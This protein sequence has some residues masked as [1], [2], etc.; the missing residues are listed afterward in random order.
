M[1]WQGYC[2]R[3][4]SRIS[5]IAGIH[6]WPLQLGNLSL[7]RSRRSATYLADRGSGKGYS[8]SV[9]GG[10]VFGTRNEDI[11]VLRGIAV[12]LVVLHHS[13]VIPIPAGYL[14][15][16]IFFVIS[17]FLITSHIVRDINQQTFSLTQFYMRRARRLLPATYCTL[18]VTTVGALFFLAPS[19]MDA[20]IKSLF[21]ALTF[22]ANIFLWLQTGYF[23]EAAAL[24][25][26]LHLW[27]LSIE[28]QYYLILPLFLLTVP[29]HWRVPFIGIALISSLVLC[30]VLIGYEP[31]ATFFLLP[32]R[33][34]ELMIGSLLAVIVE[35]R[36]GLDAPSVFKAAATGVIVI[37]PFFPIDQLAP[38]FD[39]VI[40]TCAT[41]VLLTGRGE[42]LRFGLATRTLSLAGD[43]SYS[44]YLVHWPLYAFAANA[45]LGNIQ[46]PVALILIPAS[47]ALGYLQYRYVEQPFRFAFPTN[48][49]RYL[50]YITAMSLVPSLPAI[51]FLIGAT[52]SADV[53]DFVHLRRVNFGL[54]S[55]C[56][57][58]AEFNNRRECSLPGV[59]VVALW[60][61]SFAIQW[62]AGL[63]DALHGKGLIQITKSACGPIDQL[64]PLWG[65]AS[66][67]WASACTAFNKTALQYIRDTDSI[68]VVVLS[69]TFAQYFKPLAHGF[70]VGDKVEKAQTQTLR[71]HFLK[72]LSAL[73][74]AGKY[75]IIIAPLPRPGNDMNV[76]EC[77]EREAQG[78]ITFGLRRDCSFDFSS[79]RAR[80]HHEVDF[81]RTVEMLDQV[82]V[83]WPERATCNKETCAAQIGE[84][85][86]YRDTSHLTYDGSVLLARMLQIGAQLDFIINHH[87]NVVEPASGRYTKAD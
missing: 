85:P 62:A 52:K 48:N 40:I 29:K 79:Y 63:A 74:Q 37:L 16:D 4:R 53:I 44:V 58:G 10:R 56:E 66:R 8:P 57:Y 50:R 23:Q 31:S 46:P 87:A 3:L 61:D 22:T 71:T 36:P 84:T 24:K 17:G 80:W 43:W 26:L 39:A 20:Y 70:L 51:L 5:D 47:F 28:E 35:K 68:K 86:L 38:R 30:I 7:Q 72:T 15:V 41:G 19:T 21:G 65:D 13:G 81:L 34:W 77:L 73:R 64:A 32:T 6:A 45:S 2:S 54:N 59:P 83:V 1:R 75:V 14:G 9:K 25:P 82:N 78:L 67:Q 49:N 69:S 42:W 11:Q 76:G 60:G 33:M 18:S 12:C 55:V 27:S